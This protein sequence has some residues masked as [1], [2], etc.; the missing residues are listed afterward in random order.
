MPL[1][2]RATTLHRPQADPYATL[3]AALFWGPGHLQK[4]Q[5][6]IK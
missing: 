6:L 2:F 5:H 3:S 4:A 1:T